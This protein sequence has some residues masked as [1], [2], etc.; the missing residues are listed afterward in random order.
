MGSERV[1]RYTIKEA[2]R[3]M[4]VPT[5]TIRY[6]DREGLL[7]FMGR[8]EAGYRVFTEGDLAMLRTIDCLKRTGMPIKEI[9]TFVELARQGDAS[10]QARY[11]LFV[12]RRAAVLEQMRELEA[13]L[14]LI[15]H[16]CRYYAKALEAGTEAVHFQTDE[17]ADD[18]LPCE[19]A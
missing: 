5:S 18:T 12:E 9:R 3:V 11:D 19:R 2:A 1:K 17:D 13:T 4:N 10:L 16:K 6:Y 15:E 8:S 14:E 7:P